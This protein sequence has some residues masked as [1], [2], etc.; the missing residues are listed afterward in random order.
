MR[1]ASKKLNVYP[2]TADQSQKNQ[3]GGEFSVVHLEFAL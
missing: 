2:M 1:K 3:D